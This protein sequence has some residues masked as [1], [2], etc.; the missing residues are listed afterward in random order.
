MSK[1]KKFEPDNTIAYDKTPV[2]IKVMPGVRDKLKAVPDWRERLR[3][4]INEMVKDVD[5]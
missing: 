1:T 5:S 3:V 2:Q 4:F